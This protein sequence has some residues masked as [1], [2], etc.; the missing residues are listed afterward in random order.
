MWTNK[1][2]TLSAPAEISPTILNQ[3]I[4]V[5]MKAS[6]KL[7][8]ID[9]NKVYRVWLNPVLKQ[10]MVLKLGFFTSKSTKH[11]RRARLTVIKT[12]ENTRQLFN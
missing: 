8:N 2:G 6:T 5:L 7:R 10:I 1:E 9:Q 11:F 12:F 3:Y 4:N